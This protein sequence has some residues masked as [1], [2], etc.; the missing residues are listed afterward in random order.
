MTDICLGV[1]SFGQKD[2]HKFSSSIV[3]FEIGRAGTWIMNVEALDRRGD[4]TYFFVLIHLECRSNKVFENEIL[5]STER[6]KQK[7]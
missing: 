2:N 3:N 5:R 7:L 4:K 1:A 6:P